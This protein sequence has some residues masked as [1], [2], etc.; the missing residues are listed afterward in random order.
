MCNRH[1][2]PLLHECQRQA[3]A[4]APAH[5][6]LTFEDIISLWLPESECWSAAQCPDE[7]MIETPGRTAPRAFTETA[8][9]SLDKMAEGINGKGP[10]SKHISDKTEGIIGFTYVVSVLEATANHR[11]S[12][13]QHMHIY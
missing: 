10:K 5:P 13:F 11:A 2:S 6:L 8:F 1:C 9:T 4:A 12:I 3:S 7:A